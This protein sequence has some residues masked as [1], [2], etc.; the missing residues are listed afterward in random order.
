MTIFIEIDTPTMGKQ[1]INV[2]D[3]RRVAPAEP[4]E[5]G[6]AQCYIITCE[7]CWTALGESYWAT[8][9]LLRAA[10][11]TT[12]MRAPARSI[13][14]AALELDAAEGKKS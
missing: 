6:R 12:I 11:A 7:T 14:D 1:A 8:M 2:N 3:I 13:E 5:D 4:Q 9:A 10:G